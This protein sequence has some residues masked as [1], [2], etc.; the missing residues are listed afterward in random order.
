M[1]EVWPGQTRRCLVPGVTYFYLRARERTRQVSGRASGVSCLGRDRRRGCCRP[2]YVSFGSLLSAVVGGGGKRGHLKCRLV[3]ERERER[4]SN[5]VRGR[6]RVAASVL[7]MPASVFLFP[8]G[9][10]DAEIKSARASTS[11]LIY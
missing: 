6:K 7:S 2:V 10:R 11:P 1:A 4:K 9:P 3:N 5:I 8:F